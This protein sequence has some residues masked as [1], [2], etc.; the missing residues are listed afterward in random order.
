MNARHTLA[1]ALAAA[2]L[3]APVAAREPQEARSVLTILR[4]A[5]KL[6]AK[7]RPPKSGTGSMLMTASA[8]IENGPFRVRWE[9]I[10]YELALDPKDR[11]TWI[12]TSDPEFK[13]PEGV[14]AGDSLQSVIDRTGAKLVG[15]PGWAYYV[16][17]ASG[18]NARLGASTAE[19]GAFVLNI[20]MYGTPEPKEG[21]VSQLFRRG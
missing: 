15:E 16:P 9:G 8:N 4:R 18:W 2:L 3:A 20:P 21:T 13:T 1:L 7:F 19:D 14:A 11:I 5:P 17:L 10:E 12:S 6:G